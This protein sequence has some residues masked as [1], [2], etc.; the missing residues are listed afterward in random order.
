[1]QGVKYYLKAEEAFEKGASEEKTEKDLGKAQKYAEQA[2]KNS[3]NLQNNY[4]ALVDSRDKA[5]A[6]GADGLDIKEY[7]QGTKFL[8]RT[9]AKM[10]KDDTQGAQK[11]AEKAMEKFQLAE[12]EAIKMNIVGDLNDKIISLQRDG[13]MKWSPKTFEEAE[14]YRDEATKILEQ[15]RY[16]Q[17]QALQKVEKGEYF[18][19][20][21]EFLTNKIK[22]AMGDKEN[23]EELFLQREEELSEIASPLGLEPSFEEG[24]E[25][26]VSEIDQAVKE[27][28]DRERDLYSQLMQIEQS[29]A[30]AKQEIQLAEKT[31][32]KMSSELQISEDT[33]RK[34]KLAEKRVKKIQQLFSTKEAKVL[35]DPENNITITLY[36]LNFESGRSSIEPEYFALLSDVYKAAQM[37]PDR[38]I[39]VT[40]HTDS[41]G[42]SEFNRKLSLERAKAVARHMEEEYSVSADQIEVIG[43]GESEPIAPNTTPEGRKLNR[44]IDVTFLAPGN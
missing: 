18:A 1:M 41:V 43:S 14:K 6:A 32:E 25:G 31:K 29:L 5:I 39:R 27:M 2:I 40:G 16:N 42:S 24:Y 20:K 23:W 4:T 15:N 10:Q 35:M 13:A 22:E 17:E 34:Q 38:T 8:M 30:Q 9:V 11:N 37:F 33:L 26:P 12:L 3:Q 19:R 28:I 44:R 21:A 7:N 36:G